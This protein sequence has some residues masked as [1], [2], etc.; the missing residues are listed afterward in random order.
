MN[1]FSCLTVE[2]FQ[3]QQSYWHCSPGQGG[4]PGAG[5]DLQHEPDAGGARH[6]GQRGPRDVHE[7]P[8]HRQQVGRHDRKV[9]QVLHARVQVGSCPEMTYNEY[10]LEL[11]VGS[12]PGDG[13]SLLRP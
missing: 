8:L 2:A 11:K 7:L 4:A 3:V 6:P 1:L 13:N 10:N 5:P 9:L 12:P